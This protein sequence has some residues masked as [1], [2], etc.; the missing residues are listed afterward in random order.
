MKRS[1]VFLGITTTLLAIAGIAATKAYR[2]PL[3]K[4][5]TCTK[6]VSPIQTCPIAVFT[7]CASESIGLTCFYRQG[8]H[9]HAI[10]TEGGAGVPCVKL[11][12]YNPQ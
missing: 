7:R 10:Y 8:S 3:K 6:V 12:K 4:S 9:R 1:R 11:V 5:F 2:N